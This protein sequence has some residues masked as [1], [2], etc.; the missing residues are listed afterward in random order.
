MLRYTL[1]VFVIALLIAPSIPAAARKKTS[2]AQSKSSSAKKAPGKQ[3]AG[4][5]KKAA[6]K[7]SA[8]RRTPVRR[9]AT[10]WRNR[11]MS[12]TPQRYK[13]IQEALVAKGYLQE[14]ATG[15]WGSQSIDALRNFQRDQ[16]LE[17]SGKIDS[18]S[19]IALGLGPRYDS[20]A[21]SAPPPETAPENERPTAAGETSP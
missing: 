21:N 7:K 18:V 12:P 19:L 3:S 4:T 8:K 14:P 17:P 2:P 1:A 16:H 20:A 9:R 13:E 10:T 5:T 11:Q 6:T 15:V